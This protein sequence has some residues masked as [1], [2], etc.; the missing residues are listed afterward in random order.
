MCRVLSKPAIKQPEFIREYFKVKG[1]IA[2][3][4]IFEDDPDYGLF[5]KQQIER[6]KK[7]SLERDLAGRILQR[8][9][10]MKRLY[11]DRAG[12]SRLP[13]KSLLKTCKVNSVKATELDAPSP[14][15]QL[16][17]T[18]RKRTGIRNFDIDETKWALF[19]TG[20]S[21]S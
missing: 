16:R 14:H 3:W 9:E 7:K 17:F 2:Y 6:E 21:Y 12:H 1:G 8:Q 13:G 19:D 5:V 18:S 11:G 20:K 4:D 10:E 15:I